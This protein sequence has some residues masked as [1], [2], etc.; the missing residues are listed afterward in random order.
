MEWAIRGS[1]QRR[2]RAATCGGTGLP[3]SM[4]Q[5]GGETRAT[6]RCMAGANAYEPA[7]DTIAENDR[8]AIGC[9]CG[10]NA[11]C[12]GPQAA[13]RSQPSA[14]RRQPSRFATGGLLG[15]P[16]SCQAAYAA[17]NNVN[18]SQPHVLNARSPLPI[19]CRTVVACGNRVPREESK[20]RADF[21]RESIASDSPASPLGRH[22]RRPR[23]RKALVGFQRSG[24]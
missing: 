8:T 21:N 3:L 23:K 7:R 9:S 16:G 24:L 11:S 5:G 22:N 2:W 12:S 20:R 17:A 4:C 1:A 6:R 14:V 13:R 15:F 19:S 10:S 18:V